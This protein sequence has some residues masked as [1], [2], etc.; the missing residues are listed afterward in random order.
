MAQKRKT[1]CP[2]CE[3]SFTI[4]WEEVDLE[5]WTC[6]FCGG[7]LDKDDETETISSEEDDEDNRN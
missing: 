4:I 6:P 3:E 7:A 1:Q 2:H 5:P